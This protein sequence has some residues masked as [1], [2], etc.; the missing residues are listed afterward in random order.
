MFV[1]MEAHTSC[2]LCNYQVRVI[3]CGSARVNKRSVRVIGPLL[4]AFAYS[5]C[6]EC[7]SDV[8]SASSV[9]R[10]AYRLCPED[11]AKVIA[12]RERKWGVTGGTGPLVEA[13][14]KVA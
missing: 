14:R 9:P 5:T 8:R 1:A 2:F 6:P 3:M 13:R 4:G 11:E 10:S 7:G 12:Y